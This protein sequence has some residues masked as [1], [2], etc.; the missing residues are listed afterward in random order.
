MTEALPLSQQIR[1]ILR[2]ELANKEQI[3]YREIAL[4]LDYVTD[5]E[6]QKMYAALRGFIRRGE[7]EHIGRGLIR[8][9]WDRKKEV[10]PADKTRCM[11]RFIRAN[12][13]E[14]IMVD[15]LVANCNVT[16][17]TAKNHLRLLVRKEIM[18]RIDVPGNKPSKYRMIK[19]PGPKMIKNEEKAASMR[20]IRAARKRALQEL[21]TAGK[22]FIA[23]TE[24]IAR[25]RIAVD[26]MADEEDTA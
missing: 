4:R 20:R 16:A 26:G 2:I 24:A 12:R 8:Y 5:R 25:A 18:R 10:R 15:D 1:N 19:D 9:A 22:S 14:S 13:R 3:E 6:K 17:G 23:A 11:N 21:D 7:V